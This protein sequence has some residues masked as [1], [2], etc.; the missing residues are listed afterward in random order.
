ML[1][2]TAAGALLL[3]MLP[4]SARQPT[5]AAAAT[6]LV[7]QSAAQAPGLSDSAFAALAARISEPGGYFD[8]DNLI[9]N[10]SSYLHVLGA[11]RRLGVA[12]GAYVGV[13]PDQNFSYI[14]QIRPRI[15][16]I[17][18]IRRDN[19]L[20]HLLFKSLFE[21]ARNRVEY[22]ALLTGR[23]VPN[24]VMKLSRRPIAEVVDIVDKSAPDADQFETTRAMVR[25]KVKRYGIPVTPA[26]METIGR[27]HQAFFE[28]G[29]DLR[30]TSLGRAPRPYYP[31]LRM[32]LLEKDLAGKQATYLASEDDF[33]F[34]KS[35][36]AR[37]LVI[38]V[39]GNLAGGHA[40]REIGKV[41]AERGDKVSA[42]YVSNVE[43]YLMREATF[44]AFAATVRT[45]PH[46]SRSVIV[47][48]YFGGGFYGPHPQSV[49]GYFSTQL[50]QTLD[51]FVSESARG[52][53][54]TYMDLVSKHNL[55]LK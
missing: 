34:L 36:E 55:T 2:K 6:P 31:T 27:I 4:L 48:S 47:R 18:D 32:L 37:N 43:F 51:T 16:F 26:E 50:L 1:T 49:P 44:D 9:S 5:V 7:A 54:S 42:L 40:L 29:L 46:D 22:L 45:L 24:D 17:I 11:M 28:D 39:V 12:G 25:A 13:G 52:G 15:A 30:F 14:A 41:M 8:S 23:A 38:P 10:E 21:M 35:L 33:Q 20:Q 53:Y 3:A 19:L